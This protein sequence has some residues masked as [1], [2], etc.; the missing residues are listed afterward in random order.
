M[1]NLRADWTLLAIFT[2][3]LMLTT[4]A[5]FS[6]P[7]LAVKKS[8]S[9]F[10]TIH[11]TAS[12]TTI[13]TAH[14]VKGVKVFRVHTIPSKVIVGNTFGLRGIVLNNS[15]ATITFANGTCT[16]P[17]L[18]A[19]NKNVMTEPQAATTASCKAQQVSLTPGKQSFILIPNLSGITYRAIAPGMTNATM[20]FKYGAVSTISKSPISDSI[21][22]VYT[23]N[24]QPAGTQ[25]TSVHPTTQSTLSQ[26]I[27]AAPTSP[28]HPGVPAIRSG[29]GGLLS[30]KYPD[31]NADV[32]AGS[33]IA[34]RGTSAPP[35]ATHT[36][37][38]VEVQT[39]QHGYSPASPQ[40]TK[41]AGDYTRW[42]AITTSPMQHGQN[43]IEAQLL[44]FPPGMVSSPNLIK[45]LVHNVTGVQ[46]VGMPTATQSPPSTLSTPTPPTPPS[47]TK[48]ATGQG[49]QSIIPLV[50]HK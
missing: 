32:P 36:N 49:P 5:T 34:V 20:T 22:R 14:H 40:G 39:N 10:K 47:T 13:S 38:N 15:T 41:G 11:K 3:M 48:E 1:A 7:V 28:G 6:G 37:C 21:S 27:T 45:H 25:P 18:I 8:S 16:S 33:L 12:N 43:E 17:L 26:P 23:F 30:I 44:C 50:P 46:V 24:I 31:K 29:S 42:T 4:A 2:M 9:S 19:F 35:N